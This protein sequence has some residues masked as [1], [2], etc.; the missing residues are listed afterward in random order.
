MKE[1]A[2]EK[3]GSTHQK[4]NDSSIQAT[5]ANGKSATWADLTEEAAKKKS[6]A[7][8][9]KKTYALQAQEFFTADVA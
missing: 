8:T 6:T 7:P 4:I 9:A 1:E 5:M 2:V 3:E